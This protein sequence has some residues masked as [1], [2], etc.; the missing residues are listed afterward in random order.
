MLFNFTPQVSCQMY[1]GIVFT[2][3]QHPAICAF[4]SHHFY[5]GK[6][7][8]DPSLSGQG[9]ARRKFG[10]PFWPNPEHGPIMMCHVEGTEQSLTVSGPDGNE[11]SKYNTAEAEHVV[12]ITLPCSPCCAQSP[13]LIY[14]V[15]IYISYF[16]N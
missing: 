1:S 6:L 5:D 10:R 9:E 4:P 8:T 7:Q 15:K 2:F 14:T 12:S 13:V 3:S 11:H 16:P